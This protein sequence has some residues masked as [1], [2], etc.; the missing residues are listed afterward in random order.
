M[1]VAKDLV[2]C[3]ARAFYDVKHV[4]VVDALMIH[5]AYVFFSPYQRFTRTQS[6]S[7][8]LS[9]S[10]RDDDLGYLLGLQTKDLHKLCGKLKEDRML[11]V[12]V[13]SPMWPYDLQVKLKIQPIVGHSCS[14]GLMPLLMRC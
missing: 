2:R 3:V 12:Y 5:N 11:H 4:L 13:A 9:S 8:S 1:D 7:R 14:L 10:L 6:N